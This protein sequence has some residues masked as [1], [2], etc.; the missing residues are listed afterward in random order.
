MRIAAVNNDDAVNSV[1]GPAISLWVCGCS[2]H[3]PG[4]HNPELWD[5]KPDNFQ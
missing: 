5:F 3:C 2:H 1:D 4:C